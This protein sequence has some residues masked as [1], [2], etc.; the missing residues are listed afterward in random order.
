MVLIRTVGRTVCRSLG[1]GPRGALWQLPWKQILLEPSRD[2]VATFPFGGV[3]RLGS[4]T[5]L[6]GSLRDRVATLPQS[7]GS[8]PTL[9]LYGSVRDLN[10]FKGPVDVLQRSFTGALKDF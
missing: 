8:V 3:W 6:E 2:R 10:V 7:S 9:P 4:Y 5:P 1:K